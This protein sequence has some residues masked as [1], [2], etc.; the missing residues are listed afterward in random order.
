[1]LVSLEH[2]VRDGLLQSSHLVVPRRMAEA[3]R[4]LYPSARRFRERCLRKAWERF[5]RRA[6]QDERQRFEAFREQQ[7]DWLEDYALFC[8][9]KRATRGRIWTQWDQALV[10]REPAA[11]ARARSVQTQEIGYHRFVQYRFARDWDELKAHAVR[12][13]VR[14]LGDV[15]M[16]VAHDGA[17]VWQHQRFF[18]LHENGERRVVAGVPPDYFSAEGQLWGNPLYDWDALSADG[19]S[20]WLRRLKRSLELFD[21][22]RLDH[23]IG[24]HR[25]WEVQAGAHTARDGRFVHVPGVEFFEKAGAALGSLPFIAE[26]LGLLTP[27][28]TALRER[29]D[30]PGMRVLLFAFSGDWREYQPHRYDRRTV[31]YT[32]THDNDTVTSWLTASERT[33]DPHAAHHLRLERERAL[34]YAASDGR[35]PHW[36]MIRLAQSSVANI[37]LVPLQDIFGLGG[38][39]RMNVPGTPRGNWIWRF[40]KERLTREVAERLRL[41]AETYER[42]P[43][44]LGRPG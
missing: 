22:L 6:S 28:V 31:V 24:F 15:P 32:G 13:G 25:Y 36:D 5:P 27:E 33:S 18:Q 23:F 9:L 43:P 8:A 1:M 35:T 26:D 30:M 2:L 17:D 19:F 39:A 7:D 3:E 41:L 21:A 29:F 4:A 34:G 42:V 16:F 11:L 38:E 40:A 37:A 14:L 12:L 44:G 20:W 10:R